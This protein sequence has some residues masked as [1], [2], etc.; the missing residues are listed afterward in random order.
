MER[1]RQRFKKIQLLKRA[2][3]DKRFGQIKMMHLYV[4]W[5]R[6]QDYYD[7]GSGWRGTWELDG[8]A[9][10]NQACHYVDLLEWLIGPIEKEQA[11]MST[12]RD[13]EV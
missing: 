1:E 7:Q 5:T 8:G 2:V 3:D 10:M 9:F 11:L 4:F 12:T 13:I 6:P